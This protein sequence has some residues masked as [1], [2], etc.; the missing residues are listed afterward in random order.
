M[1]VECDNCE[2]DGI[3]N[4]EVYENNKDNLENL[5]CW[6]CEE[7]YVVDEDYIHDFFSDNYQFEDGFVYK[8]SDYLGYL[9][10]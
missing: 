2:E 8:K 7:V 10:P 5:K 4:N 3:I 6:N 9:T 1:F